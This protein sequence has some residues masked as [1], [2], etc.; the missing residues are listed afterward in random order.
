MF[1]LSYYFAFWQQG[2]QIKLKSDEL[3]NTNPSKIIQFDPG[4]YSLVTESADTFAASY[5]IPVVYVRDTSYLRDEYISYRLIDK[6]KL[7]QYLSNNDENVQALPVYF[8]GVIQPNLKELRFPERPKHKIISVTVRDNPGEGWKDWNI[9]IIT[10][11]VGLDDRVVGTFKSAYVS[12]LSVAPFFKIG[13]RYFATTSKRACFAEFVTEQFSIETQPD[14][15]DRT[16]YNSPVSIMLG[17]KALSR[18]EIRDFR[19]FDAQAPIRPAAGEDEA[20]EALRDIIDGRSPALSSETSFLIAGNPLRLAPLAAGMAKRFVDLNR[21]DNANLPG[22]RE[23]ATLLATGIAAL[24]PADFASV[25]GQLTDLSRTDGVREEYPLLY[26]RL[27][28]GGPKLFSIYRDQF[29]AQSATQN[30]R[31]LA[32]LAICRIGQADTELI[33]AIKSEWMASDSGA[34]KSDNYR[35]AL[36][37]ALAKLGQEDVLTSR[38]GSNSKILR[39]WYHAVL[40][41]RGKTSVGPNN[42]MPMELPG[43]LHVPAFMAPRLRWTQEQW[44]V[45][46]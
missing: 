11:S 23:Q 44:R 32:A 6:D 15:I 35:A 37:V 40:A 14:S 17:I 24:G 45:V 13:C 1:Y 42:C 22:G 28:D 19:G 2:I 27:A 38:G 46:D 39:D 10:T 3:R 34:S 4:A 21:V 7:T 5:S 36:F 43:N 8:D 33:S 9:G 20:F 25:Q 26:L 18:D 29:L 12:K 31:L 16:Q 30:E 41:G